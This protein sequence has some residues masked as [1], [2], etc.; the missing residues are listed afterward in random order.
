MVNLLLLYINGLYILTI[1]VENTPKLN[2]PP[3]PLTLVPKLSIPSG[4]YKIII[5]I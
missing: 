4:I 3:G 5:I 1:S 2:K